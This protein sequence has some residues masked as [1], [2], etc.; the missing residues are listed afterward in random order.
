M[1]IV[2]NVSHGSKM[3]HSAMLH[4]SKMF[5]SAMLHGSKM[6]HSAM[7]HASKMFHSAMLYGSNCDSYIISKQ[8]DTLR[9]IEKLV[10][11][12]K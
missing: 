12:K 9:N 2:K 1:P 6:F 11:Q 7:L 3:F 8:S 5:H 4:G 10:E